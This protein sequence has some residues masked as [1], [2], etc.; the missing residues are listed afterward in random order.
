MASALTAAGVDAEN[1]NAIGGDI[2]T[3]YGAAKVFNGTTWVDLGQDQ[4]ALDDQLS[5]LVS[6]LAFN[7]E[8]SYITG[9]TQGADG[10]VTASVS[11]F[12][13]DVKTAI[14]DGAAS[15]TAN[16][17]TVSVTTTS[18]SV[19]GVQVDATNIS[20]TSVSASSG[21]FTDLTVTSTATFSATTV[22]ATT[23]TIGGSTVEQLA[24]KQIAA[25]S[26]ST[27]TGTGNGITVGVTTQSGS[28]TAVTVSASAFTNAMHYLGA[29]TVS[30]SSADG[31]TYTVQVTPP[32]G[33]TPQSGDI[34]IDQTSGLEAIYDGTSWALIGDNAVFAL[35]AY[36]S[37]ADVFSGVATV[38]GALDAVGA[39]ADTFQEALDTAAS[40]ADDISESSTALV[41]ASAVAGYVSQEITN[42]SLGNAAS[43]TYA[44][45]LTSTGTSLPTES[46]VAGYVADVIDALGGSASDADKGVSVE[47]V[48]ADG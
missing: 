28:V 23:L 46:A 33:T 40:S 6:G 21:T 35:N 24:D 13:T 1:A 36:S 4:A 15:S 31:E 17:I 42:L 27:V 3:G 11:D 14:G 43:K 19:T 39:A 37:D 18:G 34:V 2:L 12:A 29:G 30:K 32:A 9:I 16:G 48:T 45:S 41:T 7:G 8:G 47:V 10:K 25:I 38:P 22:S 5:G 26:A 20:A 44:D